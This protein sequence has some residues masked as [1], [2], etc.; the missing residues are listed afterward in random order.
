M[1]LFTKLLVL[2]NNCNLF[3]TTVLGAERDLSFSQAL[4]AIAL[5][6]LPMHKI[7]LT[8]NCQTSLQV[9]VQYIG[10]TLARVIG[11]MISDYRVKVACHKIMAQCTD[12]YPFIIAARSRIGKT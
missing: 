7:S 11:V 5:V 3:R 4:A 12:V 10:L 6:Y 9:S 1:C 8:V 2:V